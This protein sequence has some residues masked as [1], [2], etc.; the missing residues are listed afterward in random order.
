MINSAHKERRIFHLFYPSKDIGNNS[1]S[2]QNSKIY[3]LF[4]IINSM[5]TYK[6]ICAF[7]EDWTSTLTAVGF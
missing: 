2:E 1:F 6:N 3:L 5:H 7:E 4:W